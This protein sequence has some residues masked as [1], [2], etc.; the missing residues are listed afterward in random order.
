MNKNDMIQV[1]INDTV[2]IKHGEERMVWFRAFLEEFYMTR[3]DN[4]I[5]FE[6]DTLL[7]HS[8]ER[9]DLL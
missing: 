5:A 1:I 7:S 4:D 2:H 3:T 8:V 6:Y 9:G